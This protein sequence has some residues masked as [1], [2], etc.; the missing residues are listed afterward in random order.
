MPLKLPNHVILTDVDDFVDAGRIFVKC[1][2]EDT[3]TIHFAKILQYDPN[4]RISF[5]DDIKEGLC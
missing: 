2:A 1:H 3:R 5:Q 4:D